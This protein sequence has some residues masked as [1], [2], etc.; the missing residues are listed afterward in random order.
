[1]VKTQSNRNLHKYGMNN[2]DAPTTFQRSSHSRLLH[3]KNKWK[4]APGPIT[5]VV[6]HCSRQCPTVLQSVCQL[7]LYVIFPR[8]VDHAT[9][10]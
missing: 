9:H 2:D 7:Y 1:M 5:K 3:P 8:I 4:L 10:H 6:W